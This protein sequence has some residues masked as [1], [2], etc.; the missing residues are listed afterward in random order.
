[1]PNTSGWYAVE[2]EDGTQVIGY[3]D[4]LTGWFR[5]GD[6]VGPWVGNTIDNRD[7]L[8]LVKK[9]VLINLEEVL[10][11]TQLIKFK[12]EYRE[13]ATHYRHHPLAHKCSG[14]DFVIDI[15]NDLDEMVEKL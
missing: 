10:S 14:E 7:G 6:C 13:L 3:Y 9:W 5:Y 8:L 12:Q 11:G 1:M 15:F 4:V 2:F